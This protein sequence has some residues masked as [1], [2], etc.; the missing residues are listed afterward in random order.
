[1]SKRSNSSYSR[2]RKIAPSEIKVVLDSRAARFNVKKKELENNQVKSL[3][4]KKCVK[5]PFF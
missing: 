3:Q 1:M 2:T 5:L 4:Y